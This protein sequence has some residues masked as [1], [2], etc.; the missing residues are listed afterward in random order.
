LVYIR[1]F[2]ASDIIGLLRGYCVLTYNTF[3][4]GRFTKK[5]K[6]S[7]QKYARNRAGAN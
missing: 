5:T 6:V 3:F 1:R 4:L 7:R 2:L